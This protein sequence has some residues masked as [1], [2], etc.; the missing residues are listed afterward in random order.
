[1]TEWRKSS[2]KS[3]LDPGRNVPP[4][5]I[6]KSRVREKPTVIVHGKDLP[7]KRESNTRKAVSGTKKSTH[8]PLAGAFES[9][10]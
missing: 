7:G 10:W 8:E 1:V 9:S 6:A 5:T 4:M 2:T 3:L